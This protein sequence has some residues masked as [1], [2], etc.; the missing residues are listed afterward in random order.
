MPKGI[1]STPFVW[2]YWGEKHEMTFLS[3]FVG[4]SFD[5]GYV[6]PIIG[7]AVAEKKPERVK[8]DRW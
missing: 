7:W 4:A 3:G 2:D 8:Y 5:N 6:R 1:G